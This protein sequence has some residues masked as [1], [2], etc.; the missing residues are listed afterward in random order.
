MPLSYEPEFRELNVW[1]E[2]STLM[3]ARKVSADL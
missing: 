1:C 3:V 2:L